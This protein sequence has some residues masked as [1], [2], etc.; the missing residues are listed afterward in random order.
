MIRKREERQKK[1]ERERR[2]REKK[3]RGNGRRAG[4]LSKWRSQGKMGNTNS[5]SRKSMCEC[6][7]NIGGDNRRELEARAGRSAN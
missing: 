3:E 5:G 6:D 4:L 1:E 7:A 2:G